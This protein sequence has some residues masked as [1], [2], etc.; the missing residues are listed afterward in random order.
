MISLGVF[1]KRPRPR[2]ARD[3][4]ARPGLEPLESRAVP[5]AASGNLWPS[6]QLVTLSFVPDGTNLGGQYSNLFSTF[7]SAFGSASAWENAILKA[8]QTWA[9]QANINF[10]VVSDSGAD[11]GSGSYQQGDPTFGDIRIGGFDFGNSSV[12]AM[13]FL[14]PPVNNYSI[15]GDIAFNTAQVFNINGL[16]YDLYTVALHEL[17]H[18]LGLDHSTNAAAIMYPVY[19]GV[20]YGLYSDDVSGIQSIYGAP[21]SDAY[22]AAA[23]NNTINT[24]SDINSTID[25]VTLTAVLPNLNLTSSTGVDYY[26][27]TAPSGGSGSLAVTVQSSGLS[28]LTPG[29]KVYNSAQK[30]IASTAGSGD[31]GSTLSLNVSV[32][33]GQTYYIRVAGV[34]GGAF[35][36]GAY[37]LTLNLGTGASPTLPLPNTQTANGTPLSGGGGLADHTGSSEDYDLLTI[38]DGRFGATPLP[39]P[40]AARTT[41]RLPAPTVAV[42]PRPAIALPPTVVEAASRAPVPAQSDRPAPRV[43]RDAAG[44]VVETPPL[45]P[46]SAAGVAPAAQDEDAEEPLPAAPEVAPVV[47]RDVCFSAADW[48]EDTAASVLPPHG[49]GPAD[50]G[51]RAGAPVALAA[52]F[53]FAVA[54]SRDSRPAAADSRRRPVLPR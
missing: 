42:A 21:V 38:G 24:A 12:L 47:A 14:P 44:V 34:G 28:L 27:F 43:F 7:N 36:V 48:R 52:V 16:D 29:L 22:D 23:S 13:G 8:A 20:E 17:G 37:G 39:Q 35:A 18:A 53:A 41:V 25:P 10:T 4:R 49:A 6:P 50:E 15:A 2:P 46:V 5:Y 31:L 26:Q 11:S 1:S 9:Q 3:H 33:A 51:T 32:T 54:P 30:M 19:Q 40:G 45:P